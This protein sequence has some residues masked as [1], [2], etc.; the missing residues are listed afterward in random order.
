MTV[1]L[2]S[3][4]LSELSVC[5]I[6]NPLK[7][8][9]SIGDIEHFDKSHGDWTSYLERVKLFFAANEIP[10]ER[11]VPSLL[12]LVGAEMYGLIK[13]LV[14]PENV[15]TRT[16]DQ[17]DTA[18]KTHLQPEPLVIAERFRFHK[19]VQ[20]SSESIAQYVAAIRSLSVNCKF[21][22]FLDDS[23]RDKFVCG[24][25]DTNIQKKLLSEKNL[26]FTKSVEIAV[27]ME[28]A[29]KD[30]S[31]FKEAKQVHSVQARG[32]SFR[33][34]KTQPTQQ[35][36]QKAKTKPQAATPAR[37]YPQ[38]QDKCD[39]CG[40]DRHK[41][42]QTCPAIG[43]TCV[44]C[45]GRDHFAKCC[46]KQRK[47]KVHEINS[48]PAEEFYIG[49]IEVSDSD[50]EILDID[51]EVVHELQHS[52]LDEIWVKTEI[53]RRAINIKSDTGAKI[54]VMPEK[55]YKQLSSDLSRLKP[56]SV[57]AKAYGGVSLSVVGKDT[58]NVKY[59]DV[60]YPVEFFILKEYGC[61][62]LSCRQ[63]LLMGVVT[64]EKQTISHVDTDE[65]AKSIVQEF[66]DVFTGI[67]N[68]SKE[69]HIELEPD[70][71][72][73]IH[74]A[75]RLPVAMHDKVKQELERMEAAGI[76]TPVDEPTSWVNSMV[77]VPKANDKVRICLDPRDL[78]KAVKR[79]HYQ[80][81]TLEEVTSQLSGCQYFTV[82]DATSAYWQVPLDH[83]SS[84]LTC[85]NAGPFGR[86]RYL[87]MPY[88][89][90]SAQ[91]VFQKR[92]HET[93]GTVTC[94][95]LVDDLLIGGISI[96]D[97]NEKLRKTLETAREKG[98]RFNPEK[99]QL[100]QT[101]VKF[102]GE[103]L[104]RN[105]M[106]PD[107]EKVQAVKAMESPQNKKELETYM[108]MFTYLSQYCP[109]LAEKSANIRELLKK[110]SEW[111]W[112]PGH[113]RDFQELKSM[114]TA[115]P[116]PVLQYYDVRKPVIIQVDASQS[117]LGAVLLQEGRP[118]AYASKAL[119]PT[120]QAYAQIEKE[121]LAI[122]FGCEKFHQFIY[123]RHCVI[124]S[125]HKPLET[126]MGKPLHAVP[127]RLQRIRI[128]LQA[129]DIKVM[130]R[131]GR[132]I[133]VAD[134]L[135]RHY[136]SRQQS[137]QCDD[138]HS[139]LEAHVDMMLSNLPVSDE[140]LE[141][142]QCESAKDEQLSMLAI[143]IANGWPARKMQAHELVQ[144]FWNYRDELSTERG[145]YFKGEKLI[146]PRSLRR[147]ILKKLHVGHMGI[148][149]TIER[150]RDILFWPLMGRDIQDMV[151]GCTICQ[152]RLPS[153]C[154]EPLMSHDIPE[155]P[156]QKVGTD[157]F[158]YDSRK[159]LVVVD[160][161]SRYFEVALMFNGTSSS[162]VIT[163]LKSIFARHGVPMTVIS[164]NGPQ[165]SSEEFA[166]FSRKWNFTH[167]TSSP[168]YAQSNGLA[169][170]TVQTVKDV[171]DKAKAEG[172]D[173]Y[174]ALLE[175][176][177]TPVDNHAS[178]A[179]ML[180]S[181]RLRSV[182]PMTM[183]QMLP[184][185]VPTEDVIRHR[186]KEQSRQQAHYNKGSK[187]LDPMKQGDK[188]RVWKNDFWKPAIVTERVAD[189]SYVVKTQDGG[190]YRRNRRD[191]RFDTARPQSPPP[192][193]HMSTQETSTPETT[194][195]GFTPKTPA[196]RQTVDTPKRAPS[197]PSTPP[198]TVQTRVTPTP[199]VDTNRTTSVPNTVV[200]R[201]G[202]T[203][204]STQYKDYVKF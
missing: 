101:S 150:A 31:E 43:K 190:E 204:K 108:G 56:T 124:E 49:S 109:Q 81:P 132:D 64:Q 127:M 79:E 185:V 137:D 51:E 41:P 48:E 22:Q 164:D 131:P 175:R 135:S 117:G 122:L 151:Q 160:Y 80:M 123:G 104:T 136:M 13:N 53:N 74:P 17:I 166:E 96:P 147:S 35:T 88:G 8:A 21:G 172:E 203:V 120:Q 54:N 20:D 191:L 140:R 4:V 34:R 62:L 134:T 194:T 25:K 174:L 7:M 42:Y 61:P 92:M 103:M 98:V 52:K 30:A 63:S 36:H 71:V 159:Y 87:K 148:E 76:I 58:L 102:Y 45:K 187:P 125:D 1:S 78:N 50:Q 15:A 18:V 183:K 158:E 14:A 111:C 27:S 189:R 146:I 152:E 40:Y 181:R 110:D 170:R 176:R 197:T 162:A 28:T 116:G 169:E 156:W 11:Q 115:E 77:V 129:Y 121:A 182:V 94:H 202:R 142:I 68:I 105:G 86:W 155:A 66:S 85:F 90:N 198:M 167:I 168:M 91:E 143:Y 72:P 173:P 141:E 89:L 112:T 19:R 139:D 47:S 186:Q 192:T 107:P 171:L 113:E 60:V 75:R 59:K 106:I 70:A 38:S 114:I 138:L 46:G 178:P 157:L 9:S 118:V 97:H 99:T 84:M 93:F 153:N 200:T 2:S 39:R 5:Q 95:P 177:N 29:S 24:L 82:L 119:T 37:Q 12:S 199:V 130:Y 126:I 32:R 180:M 149:K 196:K 67:G 69:Y 65:S 188:V 100:C 33:P 184:R 16:L 73:V 10:A 128:R 83:E 201:S 193:Q 154:K 161:Y 179:Q 57:K 44:V 23:L 165:Y 144:E 195:V 6:D 145:L 55:L 26:T 133:P 163:Q 3:V